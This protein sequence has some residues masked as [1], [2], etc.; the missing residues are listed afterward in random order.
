MTESASSTDNSA[1]FLESLLENYIPAILLYV[2]YLSLFSV[3]FFSV[4]LLLI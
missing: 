1:L 4:L 2:F 3:L